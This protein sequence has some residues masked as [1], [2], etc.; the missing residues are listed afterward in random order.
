VYTVGTEVSKTESVKPIHFEVGKVDFLSELDCLAANHPTVFFARLPDLILRYF[1]DSK[2]RSR[3]LA[4]V[5][6]S[7]ESWNSLRA[8]H[9]TPLRFSFVLTLSLTAKFGRNPVAVSRR[10]IIRRFLSYTA[11]LLLEN[12]L[13]VLLVIPASFYLFFRKLSTLPSPII[14]SN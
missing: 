4:K 14:P 9:L 3:L 6:F 5:E 11:A 2:Y 7:L 10:R 12:R 8:M 1:R 13:K